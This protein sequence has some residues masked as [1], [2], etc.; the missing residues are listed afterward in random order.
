MLKL[1]Q[2]IIARNAVYQLFKE[3]NY[4]EQLADG[5]TQS[6]ID[7]ALNA[8]EK[9]DNAYTE[10][11]T[12]KWVVGKAQRLFSQPIIDAEI[13][14]EVMVEADVSDGSILTERLF[15]GVNTDDA[16]DFN[17][18]AVGQKVE[19][20][21]SDY[22]VV[23]GS[24][25]LMIDLNELILK[26]Q[27]KTGTPVNEYVEV[28]L[29][30]GDIHLGSKI[31]KVTIDSNEGITSSSN[32]SLVEEP[33]DNISTVSNDKK[34]VFV[35][36]GVTTKQLLNNLKASDY[37]FQTY[38]LKNA[39]AEMNDEDIIEEGA[40]LTVTAEDGIETSEYQI[41]YVVS[42]TDIQ[43]GSLGE[44]LFTAKN[45]SGEELIENIKIGGNSE[46]ITISQVEGTTDRYKLN[47]LYAEENRTYSFIG[48]S[49][50]FHVI[51]RLSFTFSWET[52]TIENSSPFIYNNLVVKNNTIDSID[53][54]KVSL[55]EESTD[56][57]ESA[58]YK[59]GITVTSEIT[60]L[61]IGQGTINFIA[62][63]SD[64]GEI[65]NTTIYR[66]KIE[67]DGKENIF[68]VQLHLESNGDITAHIIS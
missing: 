8:V 1:D 17:V 57:W 66:V 51:D 42:L 58:V 60:D 55:M 65:N 28:Q 53:D 6:D 45:T 31:I 40:V 49:F 30:R 52:F 13:V 7:E 9:M 24:R 43:K 32:T 68:S 29:Q 2:Y 33:L 48:T 64:L 12:L 25:F 22:Y 26:S 5:V 27:N 50:H 34:K 15:K 39:G 56:T 21:G 59:D 54:I 44:I 37:S 11:A 19:Q 35:F 4:E 18:V 14:S 41:E 20:K 47:I 61:K 46:G 38:K 36:E 63:G 16:I 67:V 62:T 10:K 23:R 3:E